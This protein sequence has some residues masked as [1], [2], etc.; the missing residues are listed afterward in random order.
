[1]IIPVKEDLIRPLLAFSHLRL[2]QL[3]EILHLIIAILQQE[4]LRLRGV[5]EDV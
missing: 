2:I 1:M 4:R 3:C 5:M